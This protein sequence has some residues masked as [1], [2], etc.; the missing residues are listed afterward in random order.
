MTGSPK[1]QAHDRIGELDGLRGIACA[2]VLAWHLVNRQI[3]TRGDAWG[4]IGKCLSQSWSGVDLFFVLSGYLIVRNLARDVGTAGW[5]RRFVAARVF[6]L[7]PAYGLLLAGC[8]FLTAWVA[9][10]P[11]ASAAQAYLVQ[12]GNPLWVYAC[13]AQNWYPILVHVV[14]P[15]G[16]EFLSVTWSL[17]AEVEFYAAS[18]VLF[19]LCPARLR[20]RVLIGAAAAALC[21][22]LF[23]VATYPFPGIAALILPPARMD[24]FA[25][26]GCAALWLE[27]PRS[28]ESAARRLPALKGFWALLLALV[29]LLTFSEAPFVGRVPALF[30]YAC[31]ALFYSLSVVIIVLRAGSPGLGWIRGGPLAALG[32][33]SYG[34]YL[35][36]K[37]F[38]LLFSS[39]MGIPDA[40]LTLP[41]GV[42]YLLLELALLLILSSAVWVCIEKPAMRLGRIVSRHGR[43]G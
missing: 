43:P 4:W 16:S 20:L 35:F 38:H 26:G 33:I 25:L 2:S 24:G 22:R 7:A 11:S 27:D 19:L 40:Y 9:R 23:I 30:S 10:S 37:P 21:F 5:I 3:A 41:G 13:F 31:F 12:D 1:P 42:G 8:A 34:V 29:L 14:R 18:V 32:I 17:G 39:A 36:H 6:R 15:L 28:R